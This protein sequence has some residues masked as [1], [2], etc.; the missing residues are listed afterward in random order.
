[1]FFYFFSLSLSFS[2]YYVYYIALYRLNTHS[3]LIPRKNVCVNNAIEGLFTSSEIAVFLA[4]SI[5]REWIWKREETKKKNILNR[6]KQNQIAAN[7]LG[8]WCTQM[9]TGALLGLPQYQGISHSLTHTHTQSEMR[10]HEHIYVSYSVFHREPQSNS[11]SNR[12]RCT[13]KC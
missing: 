8:F 11:R 2:S 5:M 6:G 1:M 4:R 12:K 7:K 3:L 9:E 13:E 10:R